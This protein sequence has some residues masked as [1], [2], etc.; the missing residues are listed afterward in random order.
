MRQPMQSIW[1]NLDIKAAFLHIRRLVEVF[2]AVVVNCQ[3]FPLL[4]T[5]MVGVGVLWNFSS[6]HSDLIINFNKDILDDDVVTM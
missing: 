6:S 4:A 2:K 5:S 1:P 3:L